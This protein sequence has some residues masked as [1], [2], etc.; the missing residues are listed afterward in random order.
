MGGAGLLYLYEEA[1]TSEL[2]CLCPKYAAEFER[3]EHNVDKESHIIPNAY[4]YRSYFLGEDGHLHV[5]L[6][7][8]SGHLKLTQEL[9]EARKR[10]HI[11]PGS[12]CRLKYS[13][14]ASREALGKEAEAEIF[15]AET[16][17]ALIR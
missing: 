12:V 5:L 3:L 4:S 16:S 13:I 7:L 10:G 14:K 1:S 15:T 11:V 2:V 9:V 6:R 17:V 8:T